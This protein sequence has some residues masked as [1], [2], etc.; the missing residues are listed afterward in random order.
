M[1]RGYLA[2]FATY[3]IWGFSPIYWKIISDI[4]AIET[5][6]LRVFWSL[7]F[8]AIVFAIKKDV[9]FLKFKGH[10]VSNKKGER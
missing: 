1:N 7:P 2:A 6:G 10:N 3:L 9:T 8:L 5:L 4:P